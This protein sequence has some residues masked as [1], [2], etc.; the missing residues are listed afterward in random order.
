[1]PSVKSVQ[2][3][4][5][6]RLAQWINWADKDYIAARHLLLADLLVQ[7]SGLSNTAIEKYFKAL[8]VLLDLKNRREHNI[9]KLNDRLKENGL[10]L[11]INEEYLRLIAKSYKLRYFDDLPSEFNIMLIKTKLLVELDRTVYEIRKGF[12]F[13]KNN[14]CV[15]AGNEIWQNGKNP[16]LLNKNCCFGDFDKHDLFKEP[17][18][19]YELRVLLDGSILEVGYVTNDVINDDGKFEIEGLKP[20]SPGLL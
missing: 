1:M 5:A 6:I 13:F 16:V 20:N 14:E 11:Q 17:S 4:Q 15:G 10:K 9:C 7:G 18:Y 2:G 8:F 12:K 3:N 19:C